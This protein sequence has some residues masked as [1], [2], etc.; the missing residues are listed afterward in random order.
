MRW[1][2]STIRAARAR[3]PNVVEST[4]L[5]L[6]GAAATRSRTETAGAS[7]AASGRGRFFALTRDPPAE[8]AEWMTGRSSM[9]ASS[10]RSNE[11]RRPLARR[12][13]R[14]R[15][16]HSP[17]DRRERAARRDRHSSRADPAW[18][19]RA[20]DAIP[21]ILTSGPPALRPDRRE[22]GLLR[23]ARE[24]KCTG[25]SWHTAGI[26]VAMEVADPWSTSS[27]SSSGACADGNA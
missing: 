19:R 4:G 25:P 14:A 12:R 23:R 6:S 15:C 1:T 2:G 27:A 24:A 8:V 20:S 13:R 26:S 7:T 5:S 18:R 3:S 10:M 11:Q 9:P 22:R 17:T 21:V 16:K